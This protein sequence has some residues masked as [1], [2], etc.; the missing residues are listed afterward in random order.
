MSWF[1]RGAAIGEA[2]PA[3]IASGHHADTRTRH[4][5]GRGTVAG[6]G[7]MSRSSF[8]AQL[9]MVQATLA[10]LLKSAGFSRHGRS[11]NRRTED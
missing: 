3:A 8:A 9:D 4:K 7:P 5:D 1:E 6:R 11:F 10:G 2:A